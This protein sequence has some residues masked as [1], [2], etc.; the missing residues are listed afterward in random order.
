MLPKTIVTT[1]TAVPRSSGD[2][3]VLAVV[4][5]PLAKPAREHGLDREIELLVRVVR[6]VAA[7]I[8]L[9]DRLEL[10]DEVLQGGGVEVGV[11]LRARA[12]PWRLRARGR[13]ARR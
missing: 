1:L 12:S 3:L 8:G 9:D 5:G 4:A 13:N 10:G 6:E 11:L 7:G 2:G